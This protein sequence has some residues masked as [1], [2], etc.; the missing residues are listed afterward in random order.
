MAVQSPEAIS[1]AQKAGLILHQKGTRFWTCCPLHGEKTPSMCFFPDGKYHC[2]G[3]GAH[4]DAA[5]LYAALHGVSLA[6]ALRI[7]K[8]ESF[9]PAPRAPTAADLRRKVEAWKSWKWAQ[10]CAELHEAQAVMIQI[11]NTHTAAQLM[12]LDAYWEAIDRMAAA[13]DTL[14][15]LESASPAQLLKMCA[16]DKWEHTKMN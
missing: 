8:G 14:N 6:E 1:I 7:V 15:L 16:E 5:D 13:N 9:R 2:F 12:T 3:C 4:G 11:E 10:A